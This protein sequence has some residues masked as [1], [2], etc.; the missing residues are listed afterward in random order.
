M[1]YSLLVFSRLFGT[2]V[3]LKPRTMLQPQALSFLIAIGHT[4][5]DT[6]ITSAYIIKHILTLIISIVVIVAIGGVPEDRV[7]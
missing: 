6:Q 3:H 7:P 4:H 5:T 2:V 1:S